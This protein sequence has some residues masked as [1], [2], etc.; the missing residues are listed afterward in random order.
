MGN[1]TSRPVEEPSSST[2]IIPK[3]IP[4]NKK[5]LIIIKNTLKI[6][7]LLDNFAAEKIIKKFCKA[8]FAR[9]SRLIYIQNTMEL[10]NHK[11]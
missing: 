3:T 10:F 1:F 6:T 5:N 11:P 7:F 4:P 9:Y 8:F 2:F